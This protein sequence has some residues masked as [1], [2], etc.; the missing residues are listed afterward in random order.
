MNTTDEKPNVSEI[1]TLLP[2]HAAGTLSRRDTQR[3][4]DALAAD[5]ELA[6][7]YEL[8]REELGE[9]IHANETLGAPSARAM[10]KLF[11]A[12]DAEPARAQKPSF[13]LGAWL[14]DFVGGFQ[15]RTLAYAG[16]AAMLAI[17]LQAAVIT[18]VVMKDDA[19]PSRGFT[20][21]SAPAAGVGAA[22]SFAM[23][24][25]APGASAAEISA[26]L[27]ANKLKIVDG[28]NA[29]GMFKVQVA[30]TALPK[31]ALAQAVR[32]LQQNKVVGIIATV[33]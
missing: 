15:P 20:T 32:Q 14:A 6:R 25:F 7:R 17:M 33:D 11:A 23:L 24:Q 3:V 2:W 1:E 8:V 27:T 4:D 28:P 31:G 18:G 16:T 21:A 26:F 12:I 22:G 30:V 9:T 10:Q 13:S 5:P 19:A 29:A